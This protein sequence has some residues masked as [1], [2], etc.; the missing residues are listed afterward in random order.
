MVDAQVATKV[1]GGDGDIRQVVGHGGGDDEGVSWY[2][3]CRRHW[4]LCECRSVGWHAKVRLSYAK[5]SF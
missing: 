5:A 1:S 4:R 2:R 3:P